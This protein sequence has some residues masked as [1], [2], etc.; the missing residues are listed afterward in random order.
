VINP[1]PTLAFC[2]AHIDLNWGDLVWGIDRQLITWEDVRGFARLRAADGKIPAL[3]IEL[4]IAALERNSAS[5]IMD[6]AK[7]AA[8]PVNSLAEYE[9]Q[10]KWLFLLLKWVFENQKLFVDA[11]AV[12][13]DLYVQFGCPADVEPFVYYLP[14]RD[15]W[16]PLKHSREENLNRMMLH[17]E[18]FLKNSPLN[19]RQPK[20][21]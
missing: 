19:D 12:V 4:R 5:E 20:F 17:W 6:L 3:E 2:F 11:L 9:S 18:Q 8:Q 1:S 13:A 21:A 10:S 15:E 16:D 14:S 7:A